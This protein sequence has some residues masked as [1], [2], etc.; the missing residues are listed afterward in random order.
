[1]FRCFTR[2]FK[3]NKNLIYKNI[4]GIFIKNLI[5]KIIMRFGS[6]V[7]Y[8]LLVLHYLG[9]EFAIRFCEFYY[10]E[11]RHNMNETAIII[12]FYLFLFC[13]LFTISLHFILG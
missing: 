9:K 7:K 1:M 4:T 6:K 12:H 3:I 5:K 10:R 2:I 8:Y 11:S 13:V